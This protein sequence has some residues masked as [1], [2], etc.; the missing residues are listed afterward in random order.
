MVA[1][2]TYGDMSEMEW[3]K[4]LLGQGEQGQMFMFLFCCIPKLAPIASQEFCSLT[5][6]IIIYTHI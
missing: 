5:N 6:F 1:C 3:V 4:E 2:G